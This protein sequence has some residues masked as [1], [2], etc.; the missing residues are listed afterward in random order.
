MSVFA[1]RLRELRTENNLSMK[2]LAQAIN[3]TDGAISNWENEVNEPK[4]SYLVRLAQFFNVSA[5]YLL[6]LKDD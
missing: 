2:Q 5:D 3:T 1:T 4:I 6:G